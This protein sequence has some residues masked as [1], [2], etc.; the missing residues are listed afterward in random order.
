MRKD[1]SRSASLTMISRAR[2]SGCAVAR[3]FWG[4]ECLRRSAAPSAARRGAAHPPTRRSRARGAAAAARHQWRAL[5]HA[6]PQRAVLDVFTCAR[7]HTHLD[8]AGRLLS[9]NAE[10]HLKTAAEMTRA[11]SRSAGGHR[12]TPSRSPSGWNFGSSDLGYEFPHFRRARRAKPKRPFCAQ[13]VLEGARERFRE[14]FDERTRGA[15]RQGTDAHRAARLLRLLPLHLGSRGVRQRAEH[16]GAGPRQRGE[17]RGLLFARHHG[18]RS[19][20]LPICSSSAF[21]R[22]GRNSWPDI[23]LDLPSGDRRERVIQEVY[24]R[25]GKHGAAMT[26]NVI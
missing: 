22:E 5:R 26:A 4:E 21:S 11:F 15:T 19:D 3:S 18:L 14:K 20:R 7:H 23:D 2:R 10:R 16:H 17:F 9:A 6:P 25:Y 12:S 24:R 1:R 13:R 8:A